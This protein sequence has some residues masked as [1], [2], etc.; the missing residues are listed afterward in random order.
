MVGLENARMQVV[1][2]SVFSVGKYSYCLLQECFVDTELQVLLGRGLLQSL[3]GEGPV[4]RLGPAL[5]RKQIA[6]IGTCGVAASD[7]RDASDTCRVSEA[8]KRASVLQPG[9]GPGPSLWSAT[10]FS[11]VE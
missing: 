1:L 10:C 5:L 2:Q 3:T 11:S 7:R 4:T 9:P 6:L 8:A